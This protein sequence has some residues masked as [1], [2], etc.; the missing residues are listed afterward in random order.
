M[1]NLKTKIPG[2]KSLRILTKLKAKNGGWG[3][4]YP[5]VLS[6]K[7]KG[8]YCEDI[9]GNV[10]L[11][12]GSQIASNP[13]GY[14]HPELLEVLKAY[15]K[16]TPIKFAGQDFAVEEHLKM[17]EE[18]TSITPRNLD[19]AFL[20]NSGAEAVE[21]AIKICMRSRPKTKVGISMERAFHGRTLGAL[22]LTNSNKVHKKGYMRLPMLRLPYDESAAEHLE[23]ILAT[24]VYPDEIGFVILEHVQGEGGYTPAPKKMVEDLR[25]ITKKNGIPYISDEIQAGIGRTGKWWAF[26]HYNIVPEVFTS[27]KA[28]Q[29]GAVVANH[30]LF[31]NE[32]G[33]ISSTWGGGHILDLAMGLKTIELIK[34]QKILQRNE[35]IGQYCL[36]ALNDVAGI[37]NQRGIGLMLAFDLPSQEIR[38]NVL[39]ECVQNGLI[40]LG[41]GIKGIRV[42]PP[43][44]VE[45]KDIDT[46]ITIIEKAVKTCSVKKFKHRGKI[47][48]FL[49]CGRSHA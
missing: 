18:L 21:N 19:N 11:D 26:Q 41:C 38:D 12:F 9:D 7:G 32:A 3:V 25:K 14:N 22:S 40:L 13:F 4:T 6:S 28:L 35:R 34:K 29:V 46:A 36:K 44:I 15:G 20:I 47:Y 24:E 16:R 10:F 27:G 39:L 17:I 5:F 48:D 30:S 33:A 23:T 43:Y 8:A 37:S 42:I 2:P 1:I 31:P 45:E 49:H